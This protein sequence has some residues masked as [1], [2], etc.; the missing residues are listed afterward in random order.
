MS[1]IVSHRSKRQRQAQ[2][3][4]H[5]L[6]K[7]WCLQID[8]VKC[9][10]VLGTS[11]IGIYGIL[12]TKTFCHQTIVFSI[13]LGIYSQ[14]SVTVGYH[15]LWSHRSFKATLLLRIFLL[16]GG[17]CAFQ[18]SAT[19]WATMHR[20]HHRFTGTDRDPYTI[21]RGFWYAHFGWLILAP[22]D[23]LSHVNCNDLLTDPMLRFQH[24]YQIILGLFIAVVLPILISHVFWGDL[25]VKM[26]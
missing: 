13:L 20:S 21:K 25:R 7:Q 19:S 22:N 16:I 3:H 18:S 1:G 6:D 8:W 2:N 24:K 5:A 9:I 26:S 4:D 12:T 14:L 17:S 23:V 15:H 11:I 10:C